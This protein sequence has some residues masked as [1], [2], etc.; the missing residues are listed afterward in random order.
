MSVIIRFG[1]IPCFFRSRVSRRLAAWGSPF[2]RYRP[3][4][5]AI[6]SA[7]AML[8]TDDAA[9]AINVA[10]LEMDSFRGA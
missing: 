10:D 2:C 6:L 4:D 1:G 3:H 5:V 7:L 9:L 8:D